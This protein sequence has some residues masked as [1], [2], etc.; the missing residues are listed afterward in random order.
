MCMYSANEGFVNDFHFFH[1]MQFAVR[2][3]GLIM[4][5]ATAVLP[6]ARI[7]PGCLGIWKDEHIDG[8]QRIATAMKKCGAVAGIQ[9]GHSGRLGSSIP[10]NRYTEGDSF[11]SGTSSGGW[12]DR[13]FGPSPVAFSSQFW[14]PKELNERQIN[15]IQ[16][17]FVSA[18]VRADKA[19]FDVIDI[20]AAYGMLL[21]QFL[22]PT[23][24]KRT[25]KYGGSFENRIR[26]LV[27]VADRVR[28]VWPQG[29]PIF[30]SLSI[31]EGVDGGWTLDNT[32]RLAQLLSTKGVD[33]SELS[34]GGNSPDAKIPGGPAFKKEMASRVK[35]NLSNFLVA[36][37][38]VASNGEHA[39]RVLEDGCADA[40]FSGRQYLRN[41]SFA[42]SAAD[43]LGV[44]VQWID[45][46]QCARP[47]LKYDTFF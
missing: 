17:A 41:P 16:Q 37:V 14:T 15:E 3:A 30:V 22:S 29:K 10:L 40:M 18:A 39:N 44:N 26:M 20:H 19:G 32:I 13:V 47:N 24:N 2:G 25:D 12:P 33:M 1:Y 23:S 21:N 38:G 42:L 45:Q 27:E 8:L 4:L 35:Q 9:L 7:T 5:E 46:Y 28:Q 31:L 11:K 36:S 6:E 34:M 43:E